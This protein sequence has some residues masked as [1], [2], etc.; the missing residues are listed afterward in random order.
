MNGQ[1]NISFYKDKNTNLSSLSLKC[2]ASASPEKI[3]KPNS[4]IS[5]SANRQL[6]ARSHIIL[7][8]RIQS[9]GVAWQRMLCSAKCR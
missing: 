9:D 8:N 7:S 2:F 6:C 5:R 1:A 4:R 3:R